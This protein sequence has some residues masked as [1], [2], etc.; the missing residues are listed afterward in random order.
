MP[1]DQLE[2]Q[3]Y[4]IIQADPKPSSPILLYAWISLYQ[5]SRIQQAFALRNLPKNSF[6]KS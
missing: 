3:T 5:L 6:I 1:L 2:I 4:H